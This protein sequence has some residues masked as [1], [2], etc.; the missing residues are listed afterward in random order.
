MGGKIDEKVQKRRTLPAGRLWG[1]RSLTKCIF[2]NC[3]MY[4]SKLSNVFVEIAQN[5][6]VQKYN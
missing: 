6:F 5:I 3:E 2:S 1:G 4:L